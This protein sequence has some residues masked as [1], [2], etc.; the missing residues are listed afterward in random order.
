M[1][2]KRRSQLA[3]QGVSNWTP[4]E[5]R[6]SLNTT[7]LDQ[8]KHGN[9]SRRLAGDVDLALRMCS[10]GQG[11]GPVLKQPGGPRGCP[12]GLG[13]GGGAGVGGGRGGGAGR[14]E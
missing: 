9:P 6:E 1:H 13:G 7:R 8:M 14:F 10:S 4:D 3:I 11:G 12:E 2:G 5:A